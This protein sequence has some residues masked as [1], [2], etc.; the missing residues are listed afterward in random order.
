MLRCRRPW[1][2]VR[3]GCARAPGGHVAVSPPRRSVQSVEAPETP[4]S[5]PCRP[6]R[7][8]R[9]LPAGL[10]GFQGHRCALGHTTNTMTL[11]N[12]A[13]SGPISPR[14][15]PA[16]ASPDHG[17]ARSGCLRRS[18]ILHAPLPPPPL[19]HHAH[20]SSCG[21]TLA[22]LSAPLRATCRASQKASSHQTLA[23]PPPAHGRQACLLPTPPNL[24]SCPPA[25]RYALWTPCIS[26]AL[27]RRPNTTERYALDPS[28]D[29]ISFSRHA[30]WAFGVTRP[31]VD[32][33]APRPPIALLMHPETGSLNTSAVDAVGSKW[34][35]PSNTSDSY[36]VGQ[37][38]LTSSVLPPL[39]GKFPSTASLPTYGVVR[40]Y[41][42]APWSIVSPGRTILPRET[43]RDLRANPAIDFRI[44]GPAVA[45]S[46]LRL[47]AECSC[48]QRR[49]EIWDAGSRFEGTGSGSQTS[50]LHE[51]LQY[52]EP[53]MNLS[54][55]QLEYFHSRTSAVS[56]QWL[57]KLWQTVPSTGT[58]LLRFDYSVAAVSSCQAP[59]I[60]VPASA[61][62][63]P[64]TFR[65]KLRHPSRL[66]FEFQSLICRD[67]PK[68]PPNTQHSTLNQQPR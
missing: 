57:H 62:V 22:S 11:P 33:I 44:G 25:S 26:C 7:P 37:H 51:S 2:R 32:L 16:M 46:D 39:D 13:R 27:Q 54:G 12:R 5:R 8:C 45:R 55:Y 10:A 24:S 61:G 41:G 56:R 34:T 49:P 38:A 9:P 29:A 31:R 60:H 15:P 48:T 43:R 3:G 28:A 6:C 65:G 21:G 30:P 18:S 64:D 66:L 23:P 63:R 50:A 14:L 47:T 59:L 58:C 68:W 19:H 1:W 42:L 20:H 35:A 4:S 52:R 36:V 40:S 53:I 67:L 17:S